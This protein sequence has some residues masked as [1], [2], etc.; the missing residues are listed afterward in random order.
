MPPRCFSGAMPMKRSPLALLLLLL[1]CTAHAQYDAGATVGMGQGMV[2]KNAVIGSNVM[3][4]VILKQGQAA[5]R[6]GASSQGGAANLAA[7]QFRP[8]A[9]VSRSVLDRIGRQFGRRPP[10]RHRP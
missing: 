6:G 5:H 9:V 3:G 4:D 7:L 10:G 2:L 1:A 8:S